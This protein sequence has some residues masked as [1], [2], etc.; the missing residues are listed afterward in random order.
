MARIENIIY[1]DLPIVEHKAA[2]LK[3]LNE[4]SVIIVAGETGSGKSTQLPKIALEAGL[5]I[6]AMIGH[7]Q[8][9]RIAARTVAARIATELQVTLGTAVG[10]KVR[11]SD[12]TNPETQIKM[13]TDGVLLAEIQTSRDLRQ[14]DCIIID[15]AHERS[16]N[17]DFLLGYLKKLI[18]RRSDL[19]LIVTSATI[20]VE[21]FSRFF[22]QAP[23]L[24]IPGRMYPVEVVYLP[25]HI[26]EEQEKIQ[27][28]DPT[29]LVAHAVEKAMER[30]LGDMLIFQSGEKE[31]HEV[32]DVL[33]AL[34]L[35]NTVLLPLY[36]RQSLRDQQR[37]FQSFN[38]RKI[39][40]T[41]NIAETSLT[42]PNIRFVIDAGYARVSRYNYRNKLQ[43]LP[44][45]AISQASANQ[46][47][48]RCGRVGP[49]ICYRL[50]T[51]EDFLTRDLFTEPEILRTNLASV[52][53]K[54][55]SLRLTNIHQFPFIEPPSYQH[56][57]DGYALLMRLGAIDLSQRLTPIGKK[58]AH[59]PIE[60]KLGRI[61][62]A[63]DRYGALTEVLIIV[64]A[65]SIVSPIEKTKTN[66]PHPLLLNEKLINEH[67]DFLVFLN[68]WHFLYDRKKKLSH[69]KFRKLCQENQLS[70]I[71]VCEWFDVHL[72]LEEVVEELGFRKNQ[73]PADESLIHK[74]LL[75]GLIDTIGL[76]NEKLEYEGARGIKFYLHPG[77]ILFKK[78]PLWVMACEIIHTTKTYAR[79]NA[80]IDPLWIEEVA[81]HLL[82]RTY[83]EPYFDPKQGR[84]MAYEK[85]TL[86]GL[87]VIQRKRVIYEKYHPKES[88]EIFIQQALTEGMLR[89]H[90]AFFQE[91]QKTISY[92]QSLENRI[93]KHAAYYDESQ[94]Y[95]YYHQH[96]DPTV[97]SKTTLEKFLQ[98]KP[99]DFLVFSPEEISL[100]PIDE[101]L[102]SQFPEFIFIK[103]EKFKLNYVFDISAEDDG[104]TLVL[105]KAELVFL[106][107]ED[108]SWLV[109]GLIEEKITYLLKSLPKTLRSRF[110]PLP[111]F[112]QKVLDQVSPKKGTLL[113]CLSTY[114]SIP[115]TQWLGVT[116]PTHL[117]MHFKII[118]DDNQ[119]IA[120]GDDLD[121][122]YERLKDKLPKPI[123]EKNKEH[124]YKENIT[125][126]DFGEI[127]KSIQ[128]RHD[129]LEVTYFL[130]LV[131][132][133]VSVSI[134]AFDNE[135]QADQQHRQGLCRLYLLSIGSEIKK[136][137]QAIL[138]QKKIWSDL[139]TSFGNLENLCE[140]IAFAA[141]YVLFVQ[142]AESIR[143]QLEFQTRLQK[144]RGQWHMLI[145]QFLSL[146]KSI[147]IL[148]REV[149][150]QF[151]H[152]KY[153]EA[154]LKP[155]LN[156]IEQQ[157]RSLF[158]KQFI[159]QTPYTYFVRMPVYLKAIVSRLDK[160]S[161]QYLKDQ[162]NMLEIQHIE[163]VF[164]AKL[165]SGSLPEV[166][167]TE[168]PWKI[169]EFRI[170]LF[171]QS[172]GTLEPV[173]KVRLLKFLDAF[174]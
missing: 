85:A 174:R 88:R 64:S 169:E 22:E 120:A 30:G 141:A 63:A 81:S 100:Q 152:K 134:D 168:F 146:I 62:I 79:C 112:V 103:G 116:L 106:K 145:N 8:P 54:M 173:S 16:L 149:R 160:L 35:P 14:Y 48:G 107:N 27:D 93:R 53:L 5:G 60:P 52:I 115:L 165:N 66:D 47:M 89:T 15:E 123:P 104:I 3:A 7:T 97:F 125:A 114:F 119:C 164:N 84:V 57:K 121:I 44:I 133:H 72:Q 132:H 171:A 70:Y 80:K 167:K 37:V 41:T 28:P 39:I 130:A 26:E 23:I 75:T 56:I 158:Q 86:F 77:S 87:E 110:S 40:I 170:S 153:Q 131:D 74:S 162:Q 76:K 122:I 4:H 151:T 6:H 82:K 101:K 172:L 118:D 38:Q 108:F 36:A 67:S 21:R 55:L 9:R 94:V 113:H 18:V 143:S 1:A 68:L 51:R 46:R 61:L 2:I 135:I 11:F 71:R 59:I 13:M 109:P 124:Y 29:T 159:K 96:L 65:L 31:I 33:S 129:H 137:K 73:I 17:I 163:K 91:N 144:K 32:I 102:L 24:E 155:A 111:V 78:P 45:E 20:D 161:V 69:Q 128:Q 117:N 127:P 105:T 150:Q 58:L 19:K 98:E 99:K 136:L 142:D 92:L 154:H 25:E 10:Y 95:R 42:V 156:D 90:S 139:Y 148:H 49:G 138:Q 83:F 147:L 126:W 12:K 50:Y 166:I 140:D 43:R 34:K 157:L